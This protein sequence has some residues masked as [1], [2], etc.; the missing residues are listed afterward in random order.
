MRKLDRKF[1][2]EKSPNSAILNFVLSVK[3]LF[4]LCHSVSKFTPFQ[5]DAFKLFRHFKQPEDM[6]IRE[7]ILITY[8]SAN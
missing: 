6:G 8:A 4:S 3:F 2:A 5:R 7:N 1:D